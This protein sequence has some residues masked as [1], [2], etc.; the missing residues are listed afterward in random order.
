MPNL[1]PLVGLIVVMVVTLVAAKLILVLWENPRRLGSLW[2]T[3]TTGSPTQPTLPYRRK[4]YLLTRAEA[5]FFE[6]LR[7]AVAMMASADREPMLIMAKVRME[8]VL[9]VTGPERYRFRGRVKSRHLDFVLCD[10]QTVSP[11]VA[12]ELDDASHERED[13]RRRDEF[14][15]EALRSA[16]LPLLRVR[17]APGYEPRSLAVRLFEVLHGARTDA[18]IGL[19]DGRTDARRA[20]EE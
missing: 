3:L 13:R 4:Q 10:P 19:T 15:D 2:Q 12:I 7:R 11:L 6:A 16:A 20:E 18:M 17:A 8:D 5:R 9:L 14:V 1:A